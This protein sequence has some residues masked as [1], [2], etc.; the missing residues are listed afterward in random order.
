MKA[1]RPTPLPPSPLNPLRIRAALAL[2]GLT[3]RR[4]AV[5]NGFR[6]QLNT[7]YAVAR[8]QRSGAK[9]P[10]ILAALKGLDA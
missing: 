2:Q 1:S 10:A 4:W 7:V 9:S 5:A 8:N 3:L 6:A